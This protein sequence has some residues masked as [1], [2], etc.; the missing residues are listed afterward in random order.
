[1]FFGVQAPL[2]ATDVDGSGR[3]DG[4][5]LARLSLAFGAIFPDSRY[6]PAVD[7]DGSGIID[8][9]DLSILAFQFGR[10]QPL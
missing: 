7:L 10:D 8:G 4:F 3:V 5:D 9:I 1:V 6:Q 2:T